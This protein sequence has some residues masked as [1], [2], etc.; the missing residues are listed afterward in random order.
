MLTFTE[1]VAAVKLR[2]ENMARACASGHWA[3]ARAVSRC[4]DFAV[5]SHGP[6]QRET[7]RVVAQY[8]STIPHR[9]QC[10]AYMTN[11]GARRVRYDSA[12]VLDDLADAVAH[13][14]RWFDI[15]RLLPEL[16]VRATIEMPLGH[17]LSRLV[18]HDAGSERI[19]RY[20]R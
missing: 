5:A 6:L 1:A 17:V 13:P 12:A 8:L 19:Q 10:A 16:G 3:M 14:V 7:A 2:G 15:M 4:S 18:T 20:R 11:V 9:P